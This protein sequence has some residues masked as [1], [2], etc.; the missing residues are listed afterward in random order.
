MLVRAFAPV[1]IVQ[2]GARESLVKTSLKRNI[3]AMLILCAGKCLAV[4]D[5][6]TSSAR[7]DTEL[8]DLDCRMAQIDQ[9][10]ARTSP[11][12]A[13]RIALN[14]Q[15]VALQAE[16]K[17]LLQSKAIGKSVRDHPLVRY[18]SEDCASKPSGQIDKLFEK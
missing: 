8:S 9:S 10:I 12:S 3:C 14:K 1:P 5:P 11:N 16:R 2:Q 7:L 6:Q 17:S 13:A 15:R 18:I 4:Q